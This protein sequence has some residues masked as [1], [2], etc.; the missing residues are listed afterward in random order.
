MAST[1]TFPEEFSIVEGFCPATDNAGR[2]GDYV[3]MKNAHCAFFVFHIEQG[4]AATILLSLS[5]AT[6]V[7]PGGAQAVTALFPIWSNQTCA[8]TDLFVRGANAAN[9]T[10][11]AATLHKIVVFKFEA[12]LFSA[13]YDC[14][15]PVTGA[16]DV[17][18]LTSCQIYLQQRYA[19][20]TPPSAIID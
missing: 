6:S 17:A 1:L 13:G 12:S 3:S 4:N 18:N 7:L 15:A 19:Q 9:F 5:E 14:I 2:T 16:S 11:S 8:T 10:T 20:G